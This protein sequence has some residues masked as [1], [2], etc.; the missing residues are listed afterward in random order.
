MAEPT[1]GWHA[2]HVNFARLLNLL[3]WQLITFHAGGQP[4]M[5]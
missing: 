2:D 5:P 1:T 3:E 4:T